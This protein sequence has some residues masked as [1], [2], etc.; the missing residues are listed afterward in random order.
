MGGLYSEMGHRDASEEGNDRW[1]SSTFSMNQTSSREGEHNM[2]HALLT[3]KS[4]TNG[5]CGTYKG[6]SFDDPARGGGVGTRR[7][8][9]IGG[10]SGR[11]EPNRRVRQNT[12]MITQSK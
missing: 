2:V 5:V 4:R 1:V 9:E 8:G 12:D 10:E 6:E 11:M 3:A 7:E